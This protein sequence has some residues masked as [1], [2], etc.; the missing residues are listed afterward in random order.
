VVTYYEEE[1]KLQKLENKVLQ[2]IFKL[3]KDD[4]ELHAQYKS[5]MVYT[6]HLVLLGP[7]N[8]DGSNEK[9]GLDM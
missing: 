5:F 6:S 3:K 9:H 8:A 4:M 2:K 7:C 1:H